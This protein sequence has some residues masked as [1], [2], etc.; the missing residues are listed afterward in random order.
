MENIEPFTGVK[1]TNTNARKFLEKLGC[2]LKGDS[3]TL[4]P[5]SGVGGFFYT[6]N[7]KEDLVNLCEELIKEKKL[8]S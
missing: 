1:F 2:V 5:M 4:N 7:R 8:E 3:F 6:E